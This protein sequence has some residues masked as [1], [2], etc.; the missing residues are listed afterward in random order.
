MFEAHLYICSVWL[1]ISA[2][3][4]ML[5]ALWTHVLESQAAFWHSVKF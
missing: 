2:V 1:C 4:W 3:A 5:L